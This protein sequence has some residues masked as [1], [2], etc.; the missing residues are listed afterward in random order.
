MVLMPL[1]CAHLKM[2]KMVNLMLYIFYHSALKN[3]FEVTNDTQHVQST[4]FSTL[5]CGW[6]L[7]CQEGREERW[8]VRF[9]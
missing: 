4:A 7:S 8:E 3:A 5:H 2:V 9:L 6:T 1:N